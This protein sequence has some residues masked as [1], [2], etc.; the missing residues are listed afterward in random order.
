[1]TIRSIGRSFALV[2]GLLLPAT[3]HAQPFLFTKVFESPTVVSGGPIN[4][5][6][7]V[8]FH[9]LG[10]IQ[11]GNGG[12]L[13]NI[14][15][16]FPVGFIGA[17][18][19][20]DAGQVAFAARHFT[21]GMPDGDGLYVSDGVTLTTIA[22]YTDGLLDSGWYPD[23]NASGT[24][25]F[26][27]K[28]QSGPPTIYTGDG[29]AITPIID[30]TGPLQS[31]WLQKSINDSGVI[32]FG[33]TLDSNVHGVFTYDAGVVTTI[34]D[35]TESYYSFA[36][37]QMNNAGTVVF[38]AYLDALGA[39]GVYLSKAG[40]VTPLADT[41]GPFDFISDPIINDNEEF[42][43]IARLDG[44][45]FGLY[46]GFDP[47]TDKVIV[48]GDALF[49]ST[50]TSINSYDI[51][52]AGQISFG[53]TLANGLGGVAIATPVPEPTTA[54]LAISCIAFFATAQRTVRK[55]I[56]QF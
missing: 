39:Q 51:N 48:R 35:S 13:Q 44:G 36:G 14:T 25:V 7:I 23:I 40:V 50:I 16:P 56:V 30:T 17:F 46:A 34:A 22:D 12:A 8:A 54:I 52:N 55:E 11:T 28:T 47:V 33:G 3:A 15:S 45:A 27:S 10:G 49:G 32:L 41:S 19:Y 24:V 43:T 38:R 31:I 4:N 29:G 18:A 53:Y 5:G 37:A 42:V 21:N 2:A 9:G 1:M 6:G 20:N 26:T